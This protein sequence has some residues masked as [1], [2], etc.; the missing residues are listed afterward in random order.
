MSFSVLMEIVFVGSLLL[1]W[2]G[3]KMWYD[4]EIMKFRIVR[5]YND[6]WDRYYYIIQQQKFWWWVTPTFGTGWSKT[7]FDDCKSAEDAID[8]WIRA[9][10][11]FEVILE[12]TFD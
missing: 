8:N 2:I 1:G 5:K 6:S 9:Q 12:K 3:V 11:T 10:R 4:F 7:S